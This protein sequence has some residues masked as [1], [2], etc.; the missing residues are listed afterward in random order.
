MGLPVIDALLGFEVMLSILAVLLVDFLLLSIEMH[1]PD[2]LYA[3]PPH[4]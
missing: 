3:Q 4:F 2:L 1:A